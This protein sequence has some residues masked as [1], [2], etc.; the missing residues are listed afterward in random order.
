MTLFDAVETPDKL[1]VMTSCDQAYLESHGPAFVASNAIAGNS[2]HIH[3]M[4]NPG[5]RQV[6]L[7]K[8]TSLKLRYNAIARG[9]HMTFSTETL[10]VPKGVNSETLRT[11]YASNRFLVA[12][13]L[14]ST[15]CAM[16][17]SDIDSIFMAKMEKLD[18][19]VGL[20][21]RESL[22]GTVG[23]EALGTKVAAGLV[24]YSGSD[25]SRNF[26][27]KVE[28]NLNT[29]GLTWFTDQVS[30]YQAYTYYEKMLKFHTFDMSVMD[31][32]FRDGSPIWTGK[33]TR[34]DLDQRY[35]AKKLEMES[36]LPSIKGAFWR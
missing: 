13:R 7:A 11:Y 31:W 2:I 16:Y 19:D 22:P 14:L 21:L 12:P 5:M 18:A 34:K 32:E 36:R 6:N 27:T 15:G 4:E 29:N 28:N 30:L 24:Y 20:F 35:L 3:L 1:C 25:G 8:L 10:Q 17:L 9:T 26:A 33:G 23:W